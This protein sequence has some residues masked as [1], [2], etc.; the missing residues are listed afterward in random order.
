M[1]NQDFIIPQ[2]VNP[3]EEIDI[4]IFKEEITQHL[5]NI[6]EKVKKIIFISISFLD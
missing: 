2:L 6:F 3:F 1:E 5:I 4:S